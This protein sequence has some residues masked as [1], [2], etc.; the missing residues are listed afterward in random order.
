MKNPSDRTQKN[1]VPEVTPQTIIARTKALFT[2]EV[3]EVSPFAKD[4]YKIVRNKVKKL[5]DIIR[6]EERVKDVKGDITKVITEEQVDKLKN[7]ESYMQ[8]VLQ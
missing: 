2:P 6:I 7:K 5:D 3:L 4:L 8:S 1:K